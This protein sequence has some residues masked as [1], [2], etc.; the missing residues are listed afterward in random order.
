M[1]VRW[2]FLGAGW[3]AATAMAPAVHGAANATLQ[4]V[5][6][7]DRKRAMALA[8]ITVHNSYEALLDDPRVDAVYISLANHQHCEWSIKALKA[9]KD[10]LCEKPLAM[11]SA[12]ARLMADTAVANDRLLVE[13]IWSRWHP[14]F[15]RMVDLV[16]SGAIGELR[17]IDSV[18]TF[19]GSLA[20]NYR[21]DPEMGGGSLFDLGPY[22]LH[23]WVALTGADLDLKISSVNRNNGSTGVDLTTQISGVLSNDVSVTAITSFARA[24]VQHLSVTG[25]L[26]TLEFVGNEAFTSWKAASTLRIDDRQ[27]EFVPVDAYQV[28]IE[29]MSA[30]IKGE[31]SWLPSLR[32]SIRVMEILDQVRLT[33]ASSPLN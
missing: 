18:F 5:A 6:S 32:G 11:N 16:Q 2:G 8:P 26:A 12:E 9:G 3:I 25:A 14:R 20:G 4:A 22:H 15:V 23:L 17:E 27:E 28:M 24:E 31:Q 13:A 29:H 7:R 1:T 33:P 10:V 30:R 19:Q 21:L